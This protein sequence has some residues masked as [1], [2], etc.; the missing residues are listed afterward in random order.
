MNLNIL[1]TDTHPES[2]AKNE[3]DKLR[4]RY[5]IEYS[6]SHNEVLNLAAETLFSKLDALMSFSFNNKLLAANQTKEAAELITQFINQYQE[7]YSLD[8]GERLKKLGNFFRAYQIYFN[9]AELI[10]NSIKDEQIE[11]KLEDLQKIE[12]FH[13]AKGSLA[14]FVKHM[15][16]TPEEQIERNQPAIEWIRKRIDKIKETEPTKEEIDTY[17]E[18]QEILKRN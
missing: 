11:E 8:F 7:A 4:Q 10:E 12:A 6:Q 2:I 1:E 9:A 3:I 15:G 5:K 17:Y 14:P 18:I 13:S 16:G